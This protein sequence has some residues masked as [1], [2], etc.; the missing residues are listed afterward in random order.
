MLWSGSGQDFSKLKKKILGRGHKKEILKNAQSGP[1]EKCI[2]AQL[3][4][5]F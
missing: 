2:L 1:E 5:I 4:R 3:N